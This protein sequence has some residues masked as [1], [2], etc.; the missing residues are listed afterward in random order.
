MNTDRYNELRRRRR[1]CVEEAVIRA[2]NPQDLTALFS[3]CRK[4]ILE[5]PPSVAWNGLDR[6]DEERG[7]LEGLARCTSRDAAVAMAER[8]PL[9]LLDGECALRVFPYWVFVTSG[10]A[11]CIG[12][13]VAESGLD[14]VGPA[15][16]EYSPIGLL[17]QRWRIFRRLSRCIPTAASM[18]KS[19]LVEYVERHASDDEFA[20]LR[21]YVRFHALYFDDRARSAW[22]LY[23]CNKRDRVR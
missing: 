19:R 11:N 3:A 4:R 2:F 21:M 15:A 12:R 20:V 14:G 1:F 13:G 9:F 7:W 23:W 5:I 18:P 6:Y 22:D 8:V 17:A 10:D 16:N